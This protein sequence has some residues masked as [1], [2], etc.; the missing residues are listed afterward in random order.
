[1]T[2]LKVTVVSLFVAVAAVLVPAVSAVFVGPGPAQ[3]SRLDESHV[4]EP[5]H[6]A[7]HLA[8][9]ETDDKRYI[10]FLA[11]CAPQEV[12]PICD[13]LPARWYN[14]DVLTVCTVRGVPRWLS[15]EEFGA[16]VLDAT[17]A[18][19]G[20]DV[21]PRVAYAGTCVDELW[22]G[23]GVNQIAFDDTGSALAGTDLA[24]ARSLI[25]WPAGDHARPEIREA[26]IMLAPKLLDVPTCL[27]SAITH[28]L[29]HLLGLG[30]STDARDIMY[31]SVSL[32][33]TPSCKLTP[34]GSE[35]RR[36][37]ELYAP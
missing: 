33:D 27:R 28:E 15:A 29:G 13:G 23:N 31:A 14:A 20:S 6:R 4:F 25:A 18:W 1:M 2:A 36:L 26:D 24:V 35:L 32:S 12:G 3:A 21:A 19:N 5:D 11:D 7:T 16:Y 17:S 37:Q 9:V 22:Q 34:S 30:H 10:S 8:A